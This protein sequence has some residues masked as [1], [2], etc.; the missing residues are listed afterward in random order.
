[1]FHVGQKVEC[2]ARTV[3][4]RADPHPGLTIGNVYTIT[5]VVR[6]PHWTSP[7]LLLVEIAPR[8]RYCSFESRLFRPLVERK[9][10]IGLLT[11]L[12]DPA[13]HKETVDG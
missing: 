13:N 5:A 1:M 3:D 9:T 10:D 2:I 7:G 8:S 4:A 11:A 12:L 6:E